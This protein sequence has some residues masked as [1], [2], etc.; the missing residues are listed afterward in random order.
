MAVTSDDGAGEQP[1]DGLIVSVGVAATVWGGGARGG[2]IA[3]SPM[4][5][6]AYKFE[7]EDTIEPT[8]R[9]IKRMID[10]P[11]INRFFPALINVCP[12]KT[13]LGSII[14]RRS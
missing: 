14:N 3:C 11:L 8:T 5:F 12:L 2:V 1:E 6:D 13:L 7:C 4:L 10:I 9:R